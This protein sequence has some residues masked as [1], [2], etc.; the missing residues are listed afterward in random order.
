MIR[1]IIF[2]LS[3]VLIAGLVGVEKALSRE[4]R[5]PEDSIWPCLGGRLFYDLLVGNISEEAYLSGIIRRERWAISTAL[6]L[7]VISYIRFGL[8][9]FL[10]VT[11]PLISP[12]PSIRFRAG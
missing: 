7:A 8:R 6:P 1:Y 10:F 3:E 12:P 4:L 9:V 5:V 11:R 2:D